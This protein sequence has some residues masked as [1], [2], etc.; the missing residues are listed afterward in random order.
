MLSERKG[1][2][3]EGLGTQTRRKGFSWIKRTGGSEALDHI[4][5]ASLWD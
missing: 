1:E 2:K 4:G 3:G 5:F